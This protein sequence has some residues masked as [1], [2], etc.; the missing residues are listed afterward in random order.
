[1]GAL[2][3]SIPGPGHSFLASLTM[4][5]GDSRILVRW[6]METLILRDQNL[7]ADNIVKATFN[8]QLFPGGCELRFEALGLLKIKSLFHRPPFSSPLT[9]ALNPQLS[10]R[11]SP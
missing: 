8:R 2:A 11:L 1:M 4:V 6:N 10:G 9:F 5:K 7:D 3:A